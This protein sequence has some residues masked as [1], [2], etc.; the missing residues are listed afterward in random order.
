MI[1]K[2][3]NL[4]EKSYHYISEKMR[5]GSLR[6]GD[7]LV[8]RKLA[9]EIGV[10]VIPVREAIRQLSS[11]GLVEHIPGSGSFVRQI[12]RV[13]LDELYVLRDAVESCAAAEAAQHISTQKI[14]Q[15]EDVLKELHEISL[16]ISKNPNDYATPDQ[17]NRWI[18]C[19]EEFHQLLVEASHNR[20]LGK[21]ITEH[22]VVTS[23]FESQR[24]CSGMLTFEAASLTCEGKQELLE[25]LRNRD[26]E[27]ARTLMS[28]QIQ[29][30]RQMVL[31][32]IRRQ[33]KMNE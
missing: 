16:A 8:N 26:S 7:R 1:E 2:S 25:A 17:F 23:V 33:E 31:S 13:E 32:F 6:P 22:R 10:S 12:S 30:G 3:Q 18:D 15:M 4:S 21:V 11:E 24:N 5:D 28:S 14:V 29:R 20:L 9:E 27:R 19:E